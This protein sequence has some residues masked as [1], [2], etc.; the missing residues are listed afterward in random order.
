MD[1]IYIFRSHHF[2][3]KDRG[4]HFFVTVTYIIKSH[5]WMKTQNLILRYFIQ[6]IRKCYRVWSCKRHLYNGTLLLTSRWNDTQD[7]QVHS[8]FLVWKIKPRVCSMPGK[9]TASELYP[10]DTWL[11]PSQVYKSFIIDKWLWIK[12]WF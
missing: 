11:S 3:P 5:T 12:T 4:N 10:L 1:L 6:I 8:F 7:S 2:L 9:K